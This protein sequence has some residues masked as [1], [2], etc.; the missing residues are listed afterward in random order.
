[1]QIAT[2][3]EPRGSFIVPS[4]KGCD[5]YSLYYN[6][7]LDWNNLPDDIRSISNISTY[8][9]AVKRHLLVSLMKQTFKLLVNRYFI[10][11]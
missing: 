5:S 6:A 3:I 4:I 1:M 9:T 2:H 11:F 7:I 10:Y 8:K